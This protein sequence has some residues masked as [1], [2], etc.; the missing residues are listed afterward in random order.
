MREAPGAAGPVRG[1]SP[2]D[3]A[4]QAVKK[5]G[6]IIDILVSAALERD[7][8]GRI[9]RC[10]AVLLDVTRSK[11]IEAALIAS[12]ERF[13]SLVENISEVFFTTDR[14]GT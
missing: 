7:E 5:D 12:E 11:R 2:S 1:A 6:S 14:E 4:L 10:M 9:R 8:A 13:R 3:V